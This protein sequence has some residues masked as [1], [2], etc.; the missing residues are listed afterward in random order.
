MN[1]ATERYVE[2]AARWPSQGQHILAHHDA[3][4]IVVYQAY[5]P[6]IGAYAIKHGAFGGDFSYARMSWIKP[7]FLW[8]MY[9]SGWGTKDGQEIVLGLRLR[10]EFFDGLLA[11]AVASSFGQSDFSSHDEWTAAVAT[12]EVRLQWDPDHDPHGRALARRAIQLGLRGSVLEAFGKRELVDVIDM[13]AFVAAQ[14]DELRRAGVA[15][16]RTPVER[17]Y[18]PSDGSVARGL[19]LD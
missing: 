6:S 7:N 18:V 13:T 8:M 15:E 2:Q 14:R 9:R 16:L 4:T 5:R 17:V 11:R 10:R 19:R 1:L 3:E 12:S